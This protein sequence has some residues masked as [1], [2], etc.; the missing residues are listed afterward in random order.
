MTKT[1]T[2]SGECLATAKVQDAYSSMIIDFMNF[3]LQTYILTVN[4]KF[5]FRFWVKLFIIF[6]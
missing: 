6:L 5:S 3:A 2:E 1:E 4:D